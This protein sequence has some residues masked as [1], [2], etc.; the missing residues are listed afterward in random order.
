MQ[1]TRK[2]KL[3]ERSIIFTIT[4]T[5]FLL[6]FIFDLFFNYITRIDGFRDLQWLVYWTQ[7]SNII[8]FFWIT[9]AFI[10][11]VFDIYNLEQWINHWNIKNTV[12]TFIIVTGVVF[13]WF[14]FLPL[15]STYS[16]PGPINRLIDFNKISGMNVNTDPNITYRVFIILN[17]TI[18]HLIIPGMFVYLGVTEFGYTNT[19]GTTNFKRTMIQ[20]IWP[21]LYLIWSITL[22][23]TGLVKPPYPIIDL[24]F[25]KYFAHA[26]YWQQCLW[27]IFSILSWVFMGVIFVTTSYILYW[28]SDKKYIEEKN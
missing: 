22:S 1:K 4:L 9:L 28:W 19:K 16:K 27:V 10:A 17:T 12:F 13:M 23:A 8:T 26:I 11:V 6:F 5:G 20:F 25:E 18:K 14:G 3:I 7:L 15:V 24:G 2:R 21:A